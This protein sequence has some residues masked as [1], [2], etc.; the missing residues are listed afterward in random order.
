MSNRFRIAFSAALFFILLGRLAGTPSGFAPLSTLIGT[1]GKLRAVFTL[2]GEVPVSEIPAEPRGPGVYAMDAVGAAGAAVR[3]IVMTP[4][5]AK[6]NGRIGLYRMGHWPFENRAPEDPAYASPRG[7]VQVTPG[8]VGLKVSE[9]F[10][11]GQFLTKNQPDVWPKYVALQPRLLDKLELTI[12]EL[13]RE[14]YRVKGLS[15]MSGFRTPDYNEEGVGGGG[16]SAVS[17]HQYGDAADVYPDDL[18]RGRM[19][20][21]NRDGRVDLKDA[22]V[23]AHA[24]EMVE[25]SHPEL[26]GGIGIYPATSAHG[27]FVHIDARGKRARWGA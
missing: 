14:G 16:R 18:G 15:V 8:N 11:L 27:P 19:S 10:A 20:D 25:L 22:H 9:H 3:W 2:P 24:A 6:V 21:L 12:A 17:R 26:T 4:F 7:F 5:S 13:N 1:S 23:L